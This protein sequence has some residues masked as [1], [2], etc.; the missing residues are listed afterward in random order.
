MIKKLKNLSDNI[1]VLLKKIP[2]IGLRNIKTS[3][4]VFICLIIYKFVLGNLMTP[5]DALYACVAA[6]ISMKDTVGN[7]VIYGKNR[8]I[9]TAIGG[10]FGIAFLWINMQLF[11]EDYKYLI[12]SLGI[13]I[14]IYCCNIIK[15][16]EAITIACVVYLIILITLNDKD[17]YRYAIYRILDTAIGIIISVLINKYFNFN[18]RKPGEETV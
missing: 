8:L 10:A 18:K 6:V 16:N 7:S 11:S 4:A 13:I 12:A 9:G 3:L 2:R 17:P 1:S 5:S 14:V 15:M